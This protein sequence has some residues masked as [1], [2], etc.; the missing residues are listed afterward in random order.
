M[1]KICRCRC[2]RCSRSRERRRGAHHGGALSAWDR[3]TPFTFP[4]APSQPTASCTSRCWAAAA[5]MRAA[6]PRQGSAAAAKVGL[7]RWCACTLCCPY[8][9][10][11]I[12]QRHTELDGYVMLHAASPQVQ[13]EL[14]RHSSAG[15]ACQKAASFSGPSGSRALLP[16][17]PS[18]AAA[19]PLPLSMPPPSATDRG[20]DG[21]GDGAGAACGSKH[22]HII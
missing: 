4:H 16:T 12:T 20:V 9:R 10:M 17:A 6:W 5:S 22:C 15:A 21:Y 3:M 11:R 7:W 13:Q 18:D 19:L 1:L 14:R 8:W 2:C